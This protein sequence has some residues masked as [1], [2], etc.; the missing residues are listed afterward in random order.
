MGTKLAPTAR[1]MSLG[2]LSQSDGACLVKVA[3]AFWDRLKDLTEVQLYW[4]SSVPTLGHTEA[5]ESEMARLSLSPAGGL[6]GR[7]LFE[8]IS[9]EGGGGFS[10]LFR[11]PKTGY[12]LN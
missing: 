10:W 12:L 5:L 1:G 11:S 9:A 6:R 7:P 3:G 4:S 2:C 8:R